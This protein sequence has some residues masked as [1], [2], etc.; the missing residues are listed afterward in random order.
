MLPQNPPE[1]NISIPGSRCP[2]RQNLHRHCGFFNAKQAGQFTVWPVPNTFVVTMI[3][4][5]VKPDVPVGAL[6]VTPSAPI[7]LRAA[8]QK[9]ACQLRRIGAFVGADVPFHKPGRAS[10]FLPFLD[11]AMTTTTPLR[12]ILLGGGCRSE[13][14]IRP[15]AQLRKA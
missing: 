5:A 8:E 10:G 12:R 1:A 7:A 14:P 6:G 15:G 3:L 11:N 4:Q 2:L 9:C 13:K